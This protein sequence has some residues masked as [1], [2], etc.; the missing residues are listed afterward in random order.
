MCQYFPAL[1]FVALPSDCCGTKFADCPV[2]GFLN[3]SAYF[4]MHYMQEG[5]ANAGRPTRHESQ[6]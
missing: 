2:M 1:L 5:P 6:I 4:P 3:L